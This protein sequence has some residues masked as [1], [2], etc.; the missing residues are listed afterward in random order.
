MTRYVRVE[1]GTVREA[2]TGDAL[3]EME[4]GL[5]GT[6]KEDASDAAVEGD[7]DNEDGTFSAPD[8]V[9]VVP[10]VEDI[11]QE[12]RA[13]IELDGHDLENKKAA[14]AAATVTYVEACVDACETMEG[15]LPTDWK[16]NDG[17][18]ALP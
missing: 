13:R 11:R 1:N 7:V 9:A 3:F 10:V 14:P 12:C 18:P 17:W 6:W 2:F 8:A 16:T 5:A 15:T 4:P